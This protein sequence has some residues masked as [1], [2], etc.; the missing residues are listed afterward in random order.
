MQDTPG[1]VLRQGTVYRL[2]DYLTNPVTWPFER[3]RY[4]P[5]R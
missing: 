1:P 3:T 2:P 5:G 4:V